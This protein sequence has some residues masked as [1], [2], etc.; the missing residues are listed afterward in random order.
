MRFTEWINEQVQI[1][2][3]S[4]PPKIKKLKASIEKKIKNTPLVV[5]SDKG[6][7]ALLTPDYRPIIDVGMEGSKF[8]VMADGEKELVT[9]EQDILELIDLAIDTGAVF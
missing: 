4:L 5:A 6:R 3:E 2:E 1:N 7:L 9:K 8:A